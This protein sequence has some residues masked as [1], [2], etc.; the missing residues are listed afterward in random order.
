MQPRD[1]CI[2]TL[3]KTAKRCVYIH[4]I[5][6]SQEMCVTRTAVRTNLISTKRV[7]FCFSSADSKGGSQQNSGGGSMG[8]VRQSAAG[9]KTE[10]THFFLAKK[11]N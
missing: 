7:F 2:Y 6:D 9:L 1:V 11:K 5:Q 8:G 3:Y 10:L 4:P